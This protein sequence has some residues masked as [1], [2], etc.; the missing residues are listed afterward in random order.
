MIWL[1][2]RSPADG[3][4][5]GRSRVSSGGRRKT[6][7]R[8]QFW[9]HYVRACFGSIGKGSIRF[10]FETKSTRSFPERHGSVLGIG[11]RMG[12]DLLM[13]GSE[14]WL[15]HCRLMLMMAG[16]LFLAR[17]IFKFLFSTRADRGKF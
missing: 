4:V 11:K 15:Q 3:R 13:E 17:Q 10:V 12:K 8:H 9:R 7:D 14:E 1:T 2:C 16:L 6:V 5:L